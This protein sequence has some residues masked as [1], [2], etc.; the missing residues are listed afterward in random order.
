MHGGHRPMTA[1]WNDEPPQRLPGG[2]PGWPGAPRD[3]DLAGTCD[4]DDAAPA[5]RLHRRFRSGDRETRAA[6]SDLCGQL[7]LQGLDDDDLGTLELILA[8]ALNNV[9]E[10]AYGP[11][12]GPVE[13]SID[14]IPNHRAEPAP[15]TGS[16]GRNGAVSPGLASGDGSAGGG[17]GRILCEVRD[18]GRPMPPGGP[19]G[20]GLPAIAPPD[21]LPEGGFG[22][23]IIRCLVADLT[24]ERR[25]PCNRLRLEVCTSHPLH[26]APGS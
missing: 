18:Y 26:P 15:P 22:W 6:L 1:D 20:P 16:G 10:H 8:E 7:A 5:G 21:V 13:V 19:P 4:G 2:G 11:E 14:L 23:H 3:A 12:G 9:T 25:G 24:Y 17:G